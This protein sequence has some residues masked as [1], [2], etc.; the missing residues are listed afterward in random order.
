[1]DGFA[2]AIRPVELGLPTRLG[3]TTA[4]IEGAPELRPA[5]H[6][7]DTGRRAQVL[8]RVSGRIHTG[9][10]LALAG[11]AVGGALT[12]APVEAQI[13]F[14]FDIRIG[15]APPPLPEYDQPPAGPDYIWVPGYW[16]W[17]DWIDDYYW[18]PG[19]WELPPRPG[20]F[21]TPAWW[22]WDDG[23]YVFHD[24][25]WGPAIGYYGGSTMATAISGMAGT[26]DTGATA[27]SITTRLSPAS[28]M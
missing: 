15:Y 8:H 28:P 10:T 12:A 17:S 18:V 3:K 7:K 5:P 26:V 1:V 23:A 9:S 19:Y 27:M 2:G 4:G 25:Y 22:G 6:N 14:G 16:A 20:L 11:I 13:S 21:W 24:G